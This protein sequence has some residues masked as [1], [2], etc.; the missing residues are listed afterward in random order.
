M[1]NVVHLLHPP[2][3]FEQRVRVLSWDWL[4]GEKPNV[5]GSGGYEAEPLNVKYVGGEGD[6]LV[7]LVKLTRDVMV[8]VGHVLGSGSCG[9]AHEARNAGSKDDVGV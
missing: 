5:A 8:F 2:Y 1:A 3:C 9:A 6:H 4:D 7:L